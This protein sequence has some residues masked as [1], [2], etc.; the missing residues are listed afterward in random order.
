MKLTNMP[1]AP[2]TRVGNIS[3]E[4][5]PSVLGRWNPH[6]KASNEAGTIGIYDVIGDN[7]D[8]TGMTSSK[9]AGILRSLGA[10]TPIIVNINS[11]GGDLFE[12]LAI[13]NLLREHKA[14]VTVNV[15][16]IAAS[17]ASVV[18]MAADTLNVARA[19]FLMVHNA[20]VVAWGN[21]ND[22]RQTADTLDPFDQAMVNIYAAR[23]GLDKAEVTTM[24]DNETWLDGETAVAKGLA[25]SLLASDQVTTDS[26]ASASAFAARKLDQILA[27]S[28]LSRTERR[29]LLREY[30]SSTHNAGGTG[31]QNAIGEGTPGAAFATGDAVN[32]SSSLKGILT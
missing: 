31:T 19:G 21:K 29:E 22:L 23:S 8:E 13:Y 11:P 5:T 7:W 3:S 20:W 27:R 16:G 9:M 14:E 2:T 6:A 17:A 18:A 10:E 32:I 1:L 24:L 25:D 28:G 4:I 15:V 26:S 30:K 12:G